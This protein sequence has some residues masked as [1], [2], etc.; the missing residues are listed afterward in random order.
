MSAAMTT[1]VTAGLARLLDERYSCRA[2]LPGEVPEVTLRHVLALAQRTAS[3][4]NTQPWGVHL[5]SGEATT[6]LADR[7]TAHVPTRPPV[8]DLPLPAGYSGVYDARRKESGFALY[9][10]L[11]IERGDREARGAQAMLNYRFFGAPHVAIVTTD[12]EQGTY[13]AIDCG[14]Y[15]AT[16]L[17]AAQAAGVAAVP[18]AAIAMASDAVREHLALPED[19]LVVCA[20]ALGLADPDHPAN[21]FRTTRADVDEVVTF[22]R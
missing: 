12:R 10:S 7:L 17:L 13:G 19:R 15:V 8:A 5:L 6:A 22:V 20:V 14:G 2:F 4:C 11:G 18:Q 9:A 3:W 1:D 16:L 21:A